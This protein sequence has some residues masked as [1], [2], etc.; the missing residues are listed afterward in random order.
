MKKL[1]LISIFAASTSMALADF[2]IQPGQWEY[3]TTIKTMGMEMPAQKTSICITKEM[4]KSFGESISN[5]ATN[6]AEGCDIKVL[7]NT[8]SKVKVTVK[9]DIQGQKIDSVTD[10]NRKSDKEIIMTSD[11]T[12]DVAGQKQET[13]MTIT[14]KWVSDNC[15]AQ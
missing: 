1:V 5:Q 7:E 3:E 9:C 14:Q 4:A 15:D 10:V 2:T 12:T 8:D 11:S 13:K 6:G